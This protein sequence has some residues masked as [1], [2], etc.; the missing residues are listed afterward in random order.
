MTVRWMALFGAALML[1]CATA[2]VSPPAPEPQQAPPPAAAVAEA[3]AKAETPLIPGLRWVRD[4][5]EHKAVLIQIY[6]AA[7]ERLESLARDREP[8]TWA[9]ALDGDETVIDNLGYELQLYESG[10]RHTE[11]LFADWI[12]ERRAPPL[13]GVLT[14]LGRVQ[15]LGGRIVIVTNRLE[16]TC[17]DTRQNFRDYQIPFDLILCR[18]D[19]REK[20]PRW[21][22]VRRGAE[23]LPPLDILMWVGD[24]IEDFP[25]LDQGL[26]GE[27]EAAFDAFGDRYFVIPNPMYGSWM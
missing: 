26:S 10:L 9:V 25:G 23:G 15:E 1:G 8:G 4:S 5:A 21:E 27:D 17:E 2:Q 7:G 18:R 3:A 13:P 12:S 20:E 14:F 11:E 24:N 19:E 16:P 6:R 22:M